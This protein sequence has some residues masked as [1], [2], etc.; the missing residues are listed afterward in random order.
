[1]I[2]QKKPY[3]MEIKVPGHKFKKKEITKMQVKFKKLNDK[4][5][6]GLLLYYAVILLIL[7]GARL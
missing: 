1:M 4:S 2:E 6:S 5:E 3:R 7:H